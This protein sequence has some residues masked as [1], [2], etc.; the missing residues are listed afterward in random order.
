V[1]HCIQD[2]LADYRLIESRKLCAKQSVLETLEIIAPIDAV[3]Q[4]IV[5]HQESFTE[6]GTVLRG[7]GRLG[8]SVLEHDF[9]LREMAC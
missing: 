4:M 3:P 5:E 9:G 7:S 2:G 6:L 1:T 8:R